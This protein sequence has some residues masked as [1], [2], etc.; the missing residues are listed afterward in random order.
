MSSLAFIRNVI[1]KIYLV[2]TTK[3]KKLLQKFERLVEES[4]NYLQ[5]QLHVSQVM[6]KLR[7]PVGGALGLVIHSR[8]QGHQGRE[9]MLAALL[10]QH[11]FGANV[12]DLCRLDVAAA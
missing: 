12:L 11:Q 10:H 5:S 2:N 9:E 6:F 8:P 3:A 1:V 4:I 7:G